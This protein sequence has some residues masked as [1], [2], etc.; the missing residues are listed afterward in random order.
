MLIGFI[1]GGIIVPLVARAMTKEEPEPLVHSPGNVLDAKGGI[2]KKSVT[3]EEALEASKTRTAA[4]H[5]TAATS[6]PIEDVKR[7]IE[8]E[9]G[10]NHIMYWV[11]LNESGMEPS[12]V[13]PSGASGLFQIVGTTFR[14]AKCEGDVFNYQDNIKCAAKLYRANGLRDWEWSRYDGFDGGWG[15]R[16]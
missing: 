7:A 11:A 16:L 4:S 12:A 5:E 13:N 3:T 15:K 6:V 2:Y 1:L 8:E 9:F 14:G 10:P